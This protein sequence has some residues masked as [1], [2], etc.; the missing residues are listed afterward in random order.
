MRH[1]A[2]STAPLFAAE[3]DSGFGSGS[4]LGGVGFSF[5]LGLS[6]ILATVIGF[7][8]RF[9]EFGLTA[10]GMGGVVFFSFFVLSSFFVIG[11]LVGELRPGEIQNPTKPRTRMAAVAR[12]TIGRRDGRAL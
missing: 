12:R 3:T 10:G 9:G 2:T 6:G 5:G 8:L 7:G 1:Q 11:G 4:G